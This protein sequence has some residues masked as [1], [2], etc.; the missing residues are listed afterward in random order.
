MEPYLFR[1]LHLLDGK[2]RFLD[3]QLER[4]DSDGRK[5]FGLHKSFSPEAVREAVRRLAEREVGP[6]DRSVFVLLGLTADGKPLLRVEEHSLYRGYALR[7][8]YPEGRC[9]NF[10]VPFEGYPTS[11]RRACYRLADRIVQRQGARTAV[12]ID[13]AGHLLGADD[14]LLVAVKGRTLRVAR[15]PESPE[16]WLAVETMR[17]ANCRLLREPV[18]REELPGLDEL[19]YVDHRGVTAFSR[20]EGRPLMAITAERIARE[21]EAAVSHL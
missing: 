16:E 6:T 13:D 14:A 15:E 7:A 10:E 12:R 17:R 18:L 11:L 19:F 9:L 21:M 20:C 8:L 2:I 1:T 4:L 5:L 3:E